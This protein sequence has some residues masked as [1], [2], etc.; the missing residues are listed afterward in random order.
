MRK[1]F[2][3]NTSRRSWNKN[4]HRDR[5]EQDFDDCAPQHAST[6]THELRIIPYTSDKD[7]TTWK[8]WLDRRGTTLEQHRLREARG[9]LLGTVDGRAEAGEQ[10]AF[11]R[12]KSIRPNLS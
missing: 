8:L 10:I 9:L 4:E 5:S 3:R 7:A 2:F 1:K 6:K 11:T 12:K